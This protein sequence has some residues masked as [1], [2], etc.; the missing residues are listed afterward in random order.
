[1]DSSSNEPS[2][3]FAPP[4]KLGGNDAQDQYSCVGVVS[5]FHFNPLP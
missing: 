3:S 5:V 4:K 2:G 1:M